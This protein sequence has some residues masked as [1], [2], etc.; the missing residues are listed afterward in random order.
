MG[1]HSMCMSSVRVRVCEWVWVWVGGCGCGC[2]CGCVTY[3]VASK[4]GHARKE[5]QNVGPDKAHHSHQIQHKCTTLLPVSWSPGPVHAIVYPPPST[6][7]SAGNASWKFLPTPTP[8][9]PLIIT[10]RV[11]STRVSIV[12]ADD[13]GQCRSWLTFLR[14][15]AHSPSL[16]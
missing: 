15:W 1:V 8:T 4:E 3:V 12:V 9:L 11:S 6:S 13:V 10:L 14:R 5:R 2:G 7:F 16:W